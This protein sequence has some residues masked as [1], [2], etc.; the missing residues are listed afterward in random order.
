MNPTRAL[1]YLE[2]GEI[3]ARNVLCA[4]YGV[5]LEKAIEHDWPSFICTACGDYE[6]LDWNQER[7]EEEARLQPCSSVPPKDHRRT[8]G[9]RSSKN[10]L[11]TRRF[12]RP[13]KV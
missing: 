7:R 11:A 4:H 12:Q 8:R 5:C 9:A 10:C 2:T 3:P 1:G 13:G 6:G